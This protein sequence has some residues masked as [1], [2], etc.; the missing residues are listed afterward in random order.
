M[1]LTEELL[2]SVELKTLEGEY[3]VRWSCPK[4]VG[5]AISMVHHLCQGIEHPS[6]IELWSQRCR[7]RCVNPTERPPLTM[8]KFAD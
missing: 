6:R 4:H 5:R 3:E 1:K 8:W 7:V 2:K